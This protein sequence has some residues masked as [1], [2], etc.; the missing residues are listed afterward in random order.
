[1]ASSVASMSRRAAASSRCS[2]L[3]S[4]FPSGTSAMAV[5][6][7]SPRARHRPWRPYRD[8]GTSPALAVAS[9]DVTRSVE[10]RVAAGR[11]AGGRVGR[12]GGVDRAA[13]ALES[14]GDGGHPGRR[15]AL[16]HH[17]GGGGRLDPGL[18]G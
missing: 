13:G 6:Y 1:M 11:G 18:G 10:P 7:T 3:I 5:T 9:P 12:G 14:A 16:R 2:G 8:G 17:R 15:E 4:V